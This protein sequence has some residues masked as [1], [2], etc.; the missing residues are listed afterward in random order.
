MEGSP[1]ESVLEGCSGLVRLSA[2]ATA[3]QVSWHGIRPDGSWAPGVSEWVRLH[4]AYCLSKVCLHGDA[5]VDG[6]ERPLGLG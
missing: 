1:A 4:R 6:W 5:P 3:A 2:A